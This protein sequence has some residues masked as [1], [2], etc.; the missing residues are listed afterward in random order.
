MKKLSR[1]Q[2]LKRAQK[3][4]LIAMDVDGVLTAGDI[5]ILDSG[6]EIK[7]WNSK[8]RFMMALLREMKDPPVLAWIT[9]RK[10][11]AVRRA[12]EEFKISHLVQGCKNKGQALS[13]ILAQT[14][15]S[16]KETVFIGDDLIDLSA[17]KLAGLSVSPRDAVDE[18]LEIVDYVSPYKG[19][20]GVFR[21]VC[22]LVLQAQNRWDSL[23][24]SLQ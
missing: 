19:G 13:D 6:E 9:G 14:G 22:K 21:D 17:I 11:N 15:F 16:E 10:S 2:L 24:N 5:L 1:A 12:A 20:E 18:L 4:K 23:L 8:D 7:L 3:I